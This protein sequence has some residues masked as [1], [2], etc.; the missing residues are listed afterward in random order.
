MATSNHVTTEDDL[1]VDSLLNNG[2]STDGVTNKESDILNDDGL[3]QSAEWWKTMQEVAKMNNMPISD[4]A[5]VLFN[6]S[7]AS[8]QQISPRS[9]LK[10]RLNASKNQRM[11][12]R[13][14]QI[15]QEKKSKKIQQQ[16]EEKDAH[17]NSNTT[18]LHKNT[19]DTQTT[20]I[21][22]EVVSEQNNPTVD[23]TTQKTN[24]TLETTESENGD[25]VIL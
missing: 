9:S 2:D 21:T 23:T 3:K 17:E 25:I 5:K 20:N 8:I 13:A 18:E 11:T 12:K 10:Q 1:Y 15:R 19:G 16:T 14:T 24:H 7:S 22:E 6:S 4:F